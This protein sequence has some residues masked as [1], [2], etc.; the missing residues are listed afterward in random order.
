MRT[1]ARGGVRPGQ[2]REH[3]LIPNMGAVDVDL[4]GTKQAELMPVNQVTGGFLWTICC[5]N[6]IYQKEK[7]Y[8]T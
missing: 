2:Q 4:P 1:A 8:E 5:R 7:R 3:P 6:D